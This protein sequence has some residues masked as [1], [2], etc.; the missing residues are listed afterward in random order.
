MT[1]GE[2]GGIP[3]ERCALCGREVSRTT[4]HHT[5]PRSFGGTEVAHLCPPCHHQVHALYTNRTLAQELNSVEALRQEP[6]IQRYLA[7]VRRQSDRL[8]RVRRSRSRR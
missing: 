4:R 3:H 1:D 7:W 5:L 6:H 2:G 8:I